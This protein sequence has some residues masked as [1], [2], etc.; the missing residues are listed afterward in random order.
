MVLNNITKWCNEQRQKMS[1]HT[2]SKQNIFERVNT[3]TVNQKMSNN[4]LVP[5]DE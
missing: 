1:K 2:N 3:E 5:K 4:M